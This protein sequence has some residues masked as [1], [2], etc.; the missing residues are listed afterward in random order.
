MK[1]IMKRINRTIIKSFGILLLMSQI[2]YSC[3]PDEVVVTPPD[4][5]FAPAGFSGLVIANTIGFNWTPIANASY[6]LE[7]SKDSLLFTKELVV[8]PLDGITYYSFSDLWSKTR[9]S[10]RIKAVSKDPTLKDSKYL[11][12]TFKTGTENIFYNITDADISS[13]QVVLKW[14]IGKKVSKIVY[15]IDGATDAAQNVTIILTDAEIATGTKTI[16][17]LVTGTTYDFEIYYGDMLRG[18]TYA[19]TL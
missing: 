12:Y 16:R 2:L 19:T 8:I 9:Y 6:Q 15:Y 14:T 11:T 17:N 4:R 18:T 10:A 3:K 13:D 5:L 1:R 7:L